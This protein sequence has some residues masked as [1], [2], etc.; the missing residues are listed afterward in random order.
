MDFFLA[1]LPVAV[2]IPLVIYA[3]VAGVSGLVLA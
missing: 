3:V 2:P 1:I